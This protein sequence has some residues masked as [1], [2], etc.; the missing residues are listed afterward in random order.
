MNDLS[1]W[2]ILIKIHFLLQFLL[3][4]LLVCIV[5]LLRLSWGGG[6]LDTQNSTTS[7]PEIVFHKA[8]SSSTEW[9]KDAIKHRSKDNDLNTITDQDLLKSK[10]RFKKL[11]AILG[12][13]PTKDY[14][15]KDSP[16]VFEATDEPANVEYTTIYCNEN[17]EED[18]NP[19]SIGT[20]LSAT[21]LKILA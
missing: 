2:R 3:C 9:F 6:S 15:S 5:V 17:S 13:Q 20:R 10:A 1:S 18:C 11:L 16:T 21:L 14:Y 12:R 19:D 4:T 8:S 7:S